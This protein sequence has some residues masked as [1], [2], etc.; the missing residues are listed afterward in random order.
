MLNG[1][2]D[3][4]LGEAEHG[5]ADTLLH[6]TGLWDLV[7]VDTEARPD[8][9]GYTFEYHEKTGDIYKSLVFRTKRFTLKAPE[10]RIE[11]S[12]D[13]VKVVALTKASRDG[14]K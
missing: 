6:Q 8:E 13:E 2:R 4:C 9:K 1:V 14:A 3:D 12:R 5:T 11:E 10:A 7:W